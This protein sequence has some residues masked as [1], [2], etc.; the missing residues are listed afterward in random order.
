[1]RQNN[2]GYQ[3]P[4]TRN[5]NHGRQSQNKIFLTIFASFEL[6]STMAKIKG[7]IFRGVEVSRF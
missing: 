5:I 1:M 7:E 3:F 6:E 2:N 4:T